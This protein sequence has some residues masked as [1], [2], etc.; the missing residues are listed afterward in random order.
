L[1]LGGPSARLELHQ[2][3]IL[4]P[5]LRRKVDPEDI[6]KHTFFYREKKKKAE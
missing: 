1:E 3:L 5:R 2:K 6:K 4:T